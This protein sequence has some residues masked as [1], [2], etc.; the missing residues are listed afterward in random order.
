MRVSRLNPTRRWR[1]ILPCSPWDASLKAPGEQVHRFP[2]AWRVRPAMS[3]CPNRP[4]PS[5]EPRFPPRPAPLPPQARL[6]PAI[7]SSNASNHL[8]FHTTLFEFSHPW[9][10]PYLWFLARTSILDYSPVESK[11][12]FATFSIKKQM[13]LFQSQTPEAAQ[14]THQRP[15][16]PSGARP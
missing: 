15:S 5:P 13:L 6:R 4:R 2:V 11:C 10:Q 16:A 8:A 14:L 9:P 1:S 3:D 7:F 12:I